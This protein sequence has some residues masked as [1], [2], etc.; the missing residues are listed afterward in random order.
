MNEWKKWNNL[1]KSG[2][3]ETRIC[4]KNVPEWKSNDLDKGAKAQPVEEINSTL[5]EAD[6][7]MPNYGEWKLYP[8]EEI[9]STPNKNTFY[10]SD[11]GFKS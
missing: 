6:G 8:F 4:S 2:K 11:L 9:N 7:L 3:M 1:E 10:K 5:M